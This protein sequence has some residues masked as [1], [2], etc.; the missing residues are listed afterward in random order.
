MD[1]SCRC[2]VMSVDKTSADGIEW[3]L[4]HFYRSKDDSQIKLDVETALKRADGFAEKYRGCLASGKM[5]PEE[6]LEAMTEYESILELMGKV[7]SYARLLYSTDT[8]DHE[9]GALVQ[10]ATE[11]ASELANKL[12]FFELEWL[13]LGDEKTK[14]YYEHPALVKYKHFLETRRRYKPYKL[15]EK[16]EQLME[17]MSNT[18]RKAFIRLFDETIGALEVKIVLDSE[19]KSM[20]FAKA[21]SLLYDQNRNTR[22]AAASGITAALKKNE[23]VLTFIFNMIVQDHAITGKF[24]KYPSPMEPRNLDNELDQKTVNALLDACDRNVDM[25]ARYYKLKARLLGLDK[26]YDY[27]RYCPL[28][29]EMPSITYAQSKERVLKAY[30]AFSS[31]MAEIAKMFFDGNWIDAQVKRGKTAGAFSS[32]T[33]PSVHPYIMLNFADKIRD[34]MTMAHEL[35]HG[36]HQYMARG[37]GY[38]QM[39]TPLV[40]AET[41][42]VFGEMLVFEDILKETA[43]PKAKLVIVASKIE[44]FFATAFRQTILTRFEQMLHKARVEEGELSI[45]RINELW[46]EAN[47]KMFGDSVELTDDY[48]YWWSYVLHFVHYPFYCYAYSFGLLLVLALYAKYRKEGDSFVPKYLELLKAGGSLSPKDLMARMDVDITDPNFWQ[49]GLDML[50]EYVKMAEKLATE[51]GY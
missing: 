3:D 23:K 50:G 38:L 2:E 17:A 28:P 16:E 21:L 20:P 22:K 7:E 43:D 37:N 30:N 4:T 10:M 45:K 24:R 27:D 44:D 6:L 11:K 39:D 31:E 8:L 1:A 47:K 26:L 42:S 14:E 19:E 13:A 51:A 36:V 40:M 15:S 25:V 9:R 5:T 29:G 18:G 35:G 33:V 32:S 46:I 48:G 41:A 12:V 34:M 49:G